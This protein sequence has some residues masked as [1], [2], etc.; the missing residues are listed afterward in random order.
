MLKPFLQWLGFTLA[1]FGSLG[2]G[3]HVYLTENPARVLVVLDSSFPMQSDRAGAM[4]LLKEIGERHYT[5]FSLYT[6]KGIVHSWR[7][8][9]MPG[10]VTFYAPRDWQQLSSLQKN[11]EFADATRTILITNDPAYSKQSDD[12]IVMYPK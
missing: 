10:N 7:T 4:V 9:L 1:G 12:W 3:Y 5:E 6:E 11:R 2:G 8:R